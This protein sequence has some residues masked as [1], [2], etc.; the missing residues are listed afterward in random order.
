MDISR[1][2]RGE[3][4]AGAS[5]LAL[6]IIMFLNWFGGDEETGLSE[7]EAG[8]LLEQQPDLLEEAA[9]GAASASFNAW[10]IFDF[11]DIILLVT[12][13][14]AVGLAVATAFARTVSLPVAASAVTAGLGILATILVIYRLIDPPFGLDREFGAFLGLIAAA[15]VAIG[16]W[17]S[18]QEEGTTFAGAADQARDRFRGGGGA[19]PPPPPSG[20]AETPPPGGMAGEPREPGTTP[21]PSAPPPS[22]EP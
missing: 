1:L 2:R 11:I 13:I 21:P 9:G 16:G 15:G 8:D 4:I 20:P 14:V 6:F 19:P 18:M 3:L 22:R 7:E 10:E 17:L 12:I 5:G